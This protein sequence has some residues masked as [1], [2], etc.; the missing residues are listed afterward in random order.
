MEGGRWLVLVTD[1]CLPGQ[2]LS[3][4]F[5]LPCAPSGAKHPHHQ[6]SLLPTP[7]C[8]AI[9]SS[10]ISHSIAAQ[11][12]TETS[13]SPRLHARCPREAFSFRNHKRMLPHGDR[14]HLPHDQTTETTPAPGT[15]ASI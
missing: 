5:Q 4:Q 9:L 11:S 12:G 6:Q 3:F 15:S 8:I 13:T 14:H 1:A 7:T 10:C 2:G